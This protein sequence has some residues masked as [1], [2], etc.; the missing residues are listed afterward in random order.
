MSLS[1]PGEFNLITPLPYV[2]ISMFFYSVHSQLLK[3]TSKMN[4]SC[5]FKR[6]LQNREA[7]IYVS[8]KISAMHLLLTDILPDQF[9]MPVAHWIAEMHLQIINKLI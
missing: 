8:S 4:K 1:S 9:P 5:L 2:N 6:A 7:N 3:Q